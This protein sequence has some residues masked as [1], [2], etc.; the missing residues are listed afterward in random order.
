MLQG[1]LPQDYRELREPSVPDLSEVFGQV[2][3]GATS[4]AKLILLAVDLFC[5]YTLSHIR[6]CITTPA[7]G[8]PAQLHIHVKHVCAKLTNLYWCDNK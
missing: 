6:M 5:A 3:I 7:G 4:S 1:G 8:S 2:W